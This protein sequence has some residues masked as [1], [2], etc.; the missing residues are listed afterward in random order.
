MPPSLED[1]LAKQLSDDD[2]S[3]IDRFISG[4]DIEDWFAAIFPALP[5]S[6]LVHSLSQEQLP[7]QSKTVY[8]VPDFLVVIEA[9]TRK[10]H[11]V[12][13]EVKRVASRKKTLSV[14]KSQLALTEEYASCLGLPLVYA[15]YWEKFETWTVNTPDSFDHNPSSPKLS[16][17]RAFEL[18]CSLMFGDISFLLMHPLRRVRVFTT[19]SVDNPLV[20]HRQY[21]NCISDTITIGEQQFALAGLESATLDSI[22]SMKSINV[23]K[24]GNSTTVTEAIEEI[25]AIRLS[26]WI[27]RHMALFGMQPEE[28]S[29]NAFAHVIT[30]LATRLGVRQINIFPWGATP[31]IKEIETRYFHSKSE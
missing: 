8:Q 5:W 17:L 10:H 22:C 26:T 21:G 2:R 29:A 30:E 25:L 14:R 12:L 4:F 11:P 24:E 19:S 7:K 15:V 6:M 3:K 13:V 28:H 16:I 20:I 9:T 18:D 31:E 27:T 1:D 23:T